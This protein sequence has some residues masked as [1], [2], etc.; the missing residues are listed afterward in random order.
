VWTEHER[1][2]RA[3]D[4]GNVGRLRNSWTESPLVGF[5]AL[6]EQTM[7]AYDSSKSRSAWTTM[8][9]TT[10]TKD[11]QAMR[12]VPP[13]VHLRGE[14]NRLLSRGPTPWRAPRRWRRAISGRHCLCPRAK[15]STKTAHEFLRQ[16]LRLLALELFGRQDSLVS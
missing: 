4:T 11:V 6:A 10:A 13:S 2:Q 16:K 12:R 9:V 5:H 8:V 14:L 7:M 1:T 15:R 3:S